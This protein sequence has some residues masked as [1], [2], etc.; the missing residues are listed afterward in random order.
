MQG[1]VFQA[2]FDDLLDWGTD[3]SERN[4]DVETLGGRG[5]ADLC[6]AL[7]YPLVTRRR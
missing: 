6:G 2:E 3:G 4:A 1:S 5:D 7:R